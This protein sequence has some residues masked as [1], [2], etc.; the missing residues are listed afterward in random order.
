M[1]VES[2]TVVGAR[3]TLMAGSLREGHANGDHTSVRHSGVSTQQDDDRSWQSTLS[4]A[5]LE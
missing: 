2:I 5:N 3:E 1:K 4:F